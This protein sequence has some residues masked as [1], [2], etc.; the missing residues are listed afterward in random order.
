[1]LGWGGFPP[2]ATSYLKTV[3][4]AAG[5]VFGASALQAAAMH[6]LSPVLWVPFVV[7]TGAVLVLGLTI[8]I[9]GS[10]VLY[11]C[12]GDARGEPDLF[13]RLNASRA[14]AA[15]ERGG[16]P[17]RSRLRRWL[18]RRTLGHELI[19]GDVVAVKSWPEIQA[20]LDASGQL[21]GLPFMP[22]M[23]ALCGRR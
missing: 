4:V 21:E 6:W 3:L 15:I 13:L 17:K 5:A 22:E 20:T 11:R 14:P 1:S 16:S 12:H 8:V 23:R 7:L 10:I 19:V 9:A 2:F 18:A